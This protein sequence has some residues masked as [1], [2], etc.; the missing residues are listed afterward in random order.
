[1]TYYTIHLPMTKFSVLAAF[2]V[3]ACGSLAHAQQPAANPF[4]RP[5]AGAT[6]PGTVT[7]AAPMP[8]MPSANPGATGVPRNMPGAMRNGMPGPTGNNPGS[9]SS[10]TGGG[11]PSNPGMYPQNG[12]LPPIPSMGGM[13]TTT[14]D[15]NGV[16]TT[17]EEVSA[18]RIGLVN[19]MHI[20]KGQNT[21]MFE[22][23][24]TRK[25][26][27]RLVPSVGNAPIMPSAST[28][29]AA[30]AAEHKTPNLPSMVGKPNPK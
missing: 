28:S 5:T 14:V 8:G 3:L 30:K 15:A 1:M 18:S 9:S 17:D 12:A 23:S 26:V 29:T 7:G 2:A 6:A 16:Q 10:L 11:Y 22:P 4:A 13:P 25:I 27:R 20:Y 24:K 19:G 21:Y